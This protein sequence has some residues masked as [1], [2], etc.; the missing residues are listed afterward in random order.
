MAVEVDWEA[1]EVTAS[2]TAAFHQ[3]AAAEP[4]SV[5]DR[6]ASTDRARGQAARVALRALVAA[7]AAVV[8]V[9]GVVVVEGAGNR[10]SLVIG[11][12]S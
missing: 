4:R 8:V 6:P 7:A 1:A 9:V 12:V 5:A 3:A 10:V 11:A 2:E